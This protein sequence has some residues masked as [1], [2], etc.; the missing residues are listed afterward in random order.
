MSVYNAKNYKEQIPAGGDDKWVISGEIDVTGTLKKGGTEIT[1]TAAEINTVDVTAGTKTASKAV[2]LDSDSRVIGMPITEVVVVDASAG[3][4]AQT[5]NCTLVPANSILL[6]VTAKVTE[7]FDGDTTTTLEVGVSGNV[8][9]Y[10]DTTDFDPSGTAE[11]TYASSL[12][13]TT[14]DIKTAQW[15]STATQLIAT[16]TNTANATAG[17]VAV[18]TTFIQTA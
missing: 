10:I 5:T 18:Y 14:N 12:N 1:A 16:W 15:L 11:T 6:N 2:V 3:G 8:D 13:G 9:A 17:T 4:T 7:A